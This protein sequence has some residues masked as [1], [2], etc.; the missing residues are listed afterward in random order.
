VR[1]SSHG[2]AVDSDAE[3]EKNC[4][5]GRPEVGSSGVYHG[6]ML[7]GSK[8]HVFLDCRLGHAAAKQVYQP[9]CPRAVT[10]VPRMAVNGCLYA[11]LSG[12]S[13]ACNPAQ[14]MLVNWCR[15]GLERVRLFVEVLGCVEKDGD[16]SK[17]NER[18]SPPRWRGN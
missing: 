12:L 14:T 9:T 5:V 3:G 15:N 13:R 6:R 17:D 2:A 1:T 7:R 4:V 8:A 11:A 18:M 16:E 10:S